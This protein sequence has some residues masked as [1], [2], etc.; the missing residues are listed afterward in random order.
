MGEQQHHGVQRGDVGAGPRQGRAVQSAASQGTV[1]IKGMSRRD[2]E[3]P[4]LW[5][6]VCGY[7]NSLLPMSGCG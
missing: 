7:G 4:T 6:A 3:T 2:T 5:G 1:L